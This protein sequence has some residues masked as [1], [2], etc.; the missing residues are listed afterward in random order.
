MCC[1]LNPLGYRSIYSLSLT[2]VIL[3]EKN[4][5]WVS[6]LNPFVGHNLHV[7][8]QAIAQAIIIDGSLG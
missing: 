5:G 8:R 7:L 6:N 2:K 3:V 4:I 1:S